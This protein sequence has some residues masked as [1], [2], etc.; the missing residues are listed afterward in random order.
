MNITGKKILLFGFVVML[1]VGI[2]LTLYGLRSFQESRS[3]AT[4]ATVLSFLPDSSPTNPIKAA[5]NDTVPLDV[6]VDPGTNAV[7]FVK[8]EI[9]YDET[10]LATAEADG[11]KVNEAAFPVTLEGPVFV[12]GKISITLSVGSDPTKAVQAATKALTLKFKAL[13]NTGATP[14]TVTYGNNTEI[15][16][17]GG[18]DQAQENVLLNVNPASILIGDSNVT[19]TNGPTPTV[20]PTRQPTAVPTV[21]P[22]PTSAPLPTSVPL[23]TATSAPTP[24]GI[25]STPVANQAP[26]CTALNL[27][28]ET[29]G[30]APYS[31]T[32]TAVGNDPDGTISK[33]TF[34]YGDGPVETVTES[35]GIGSNQV[36]LP[37]SH[38]YRNSGTYTASATLT[39]NQNSFSDANS[40]KVTIVVLAA[41]TG[42]GGGNNPGPGGATGAVT[43][44]PTV[45]KPGPGDI[46]I[47]ASA[48]ALVITILGGILF[49][50]L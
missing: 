27:D 48:V 43:P 8:L 1:L 10:K 37:K 29:T 24:T 14:T 28:R 6:N 17:V 3:R 19:P 33:V 36:N 4:P 46:F 42:V 45:V 12:P 16:S 18:N 23:P 44:F 7:S 31:I 49:F 5:I 34:N 26:N 50:A 47:G 39:D 11:L 21:T 35:G 41:S 2:P 9:Q 15:L 20:T 22:Q 30:N 32:F 40:C 25:V 13:A 38:T